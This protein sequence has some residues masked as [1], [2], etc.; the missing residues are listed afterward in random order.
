M[1]E[2]VSARVSPLGDAIKVEN[3]RVRFAIN[4]RAADSAS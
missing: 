4:R 2:Q 1:L 3:D